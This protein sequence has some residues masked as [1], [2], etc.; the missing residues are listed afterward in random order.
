M[1]P[2]RIGQLYKQ[3]AVGYVLPPAKE[4]A[5]LSSHSTKRRLR[6]LLQDSLKNRPNTPVSLSELAQA[7]GV[8]RERVRQLYRQ[9]KAEYALPPVKKRGGGINK[10]RELVKAEQRARAQQVQALREK[11]VHYKQIQR[12]LGL[13]YGQVRQA[14]TRLNHERET[15]RRLRIPNPKTRALGAEVRMYSEQ[16]L[17]AYEIAERTGKPVQTIYS[18]LHRLHIPF[19]R[20]I[21]RKN[22]P[23]TRALEAEV[24]AYSAQGMT[25][26]E[27]ARKIGRPKTSVYNV[28]Y[29]LHI[30]LRKPSRRSG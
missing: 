19:K 8:S 24:R 4:H 27:I 11:G 25:P 21:P 23:K 20:V 3:L 30:P 16:G 2:E 6:K 28:F 5:N 26:P 12:E 13:T 17:T 1:T 18:A 9:L 10:Y 7:L 22:I 15:G 29:R 14:I